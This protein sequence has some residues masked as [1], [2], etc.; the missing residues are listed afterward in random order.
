M[1]SRNRELEGRRSRRASHRPMI[2]RVAPTESS[3]VVGSGGPG[4]TTYD[5][6]AIAGR[7]LTKAWTVYLPAVVASA[8][9][10]YRPSA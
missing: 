3:D 2:P 6:G 8:V 7:S 5:Q 1:E 9:R 4:L 10:E